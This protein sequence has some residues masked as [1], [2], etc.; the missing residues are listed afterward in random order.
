MNP[1]YEPISIPG[2]DAC[3]IHRGL[4]LGHTGSLSFGRITSEEITNVH[5]QL[6]LAMWLATPSDLLSRLDCQLG[7]SFTCDENLPLP[8]YSVQLYLQV[9]YAA[10]SIRIARVAVRARSL[11]TA[12][13]GRIL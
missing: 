9:Y 7:P 2:D 6:C 3:G 5:H 8:R 13:V 11:A 4:G 12:V 10:R 1:W